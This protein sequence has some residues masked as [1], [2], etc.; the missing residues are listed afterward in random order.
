MA[1]LTRKYTPEEVLAL[2]DEKQYELTDGELVEKQPMGMEAGWVQLKIGRLIGDYCEEKG[3]GGWV[4][5]EAP[6]TCFPGDPNKM[7]RPDVSFIR[8]GRLPG[9]RPPKG[10]ASVAPDLAVEVVSPNDLQSE[11]DRKVQEYLQ[12]GVR[13]VW[14]VNP[15]TRTARI[16]RPDGTILELREDNDLSGEDVLP[17][18][19]CPVRS[20][21]P[22]K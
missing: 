9:D 17:D 2:P 15:D 11:M 10:C 6:I 21:F 5:V 19:R 7:R 4:Q 22:P 20:L 1:T 3:L 13:R 8:R 14:V 12:A 16:H 18:F